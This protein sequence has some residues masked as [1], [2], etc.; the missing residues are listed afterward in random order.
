MPKTNLQ[1]SSTSNLHIAILTT[2]GTIAMQYDAEAGGAIPILG[3]DELTAVLPSGLPQLEVEEVVRMPSSHFRLDTLCAIRERVAELVAE[4]DV[5]GVVITHGTDTLEETAYLL[6]LTVPGE[7]PVVLTGAM[8]AASDVGYEGQANLLAAVRVAA[9]P[10]TRGLGAVVVFNDEI[11]AARYVTKMHT[12]STATFQS[13]GWGPMGRMEGNAVI[14]ERRPER[15]VLPWRGLEPNVVLLKL[16]VGMEADLLESALARPV[17]GVVI[18]ALGGGRVPPWWLPAIERA[19]AQGVS[20][21]IASRCPSGRV[22][23]AYGYPGAYHSL[24]D[25]GCLFAEGLNGQKARI[26]LMVVLAAAQGADEVAE[27]WREV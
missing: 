10:Q 20:V 8:R 12:L 6:D 17:R 2:G 13:P 27:L 15:R 16:A 11:H 23:D 3:A 24:A 9:A 7:K 19:Q 26:K 1:Q 14:V 5:G 4:P 21:V 18:E 22:W 25:L